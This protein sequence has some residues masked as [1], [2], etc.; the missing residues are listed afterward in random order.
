VHQFIGV[1]ALAELA[2]GHPADLLHDLEGEEQRGVR[3]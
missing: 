2:D 1:T 3:P